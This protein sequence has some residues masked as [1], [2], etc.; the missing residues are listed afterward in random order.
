MRFLLALVM[1]FF[2]AFSIGQA[3][4]IQGKGSSF[5]L[6]L[7]QKWA[8]IYQKQT[9]VSI[10][11]IDSGS[12][13]GLN[14]IKKGLT[15]FTASNRPMNEEELDKFNLLQ[16]PVVMGGV[17]PVVNMANVGP[18][19]MRLS[20]SVLVDI[21]SGKINR[22]TDPAIR[23][24]NPDIFLPA[25]PIIVITRQDPS[26]TTYLLSHYLSRINPD[27]KSSPGVGTAI[28][29]PVGVSV[30][31]FEKLMTQFFR[32]PNSITYV[33]YAVARKNRL[34]HVQLQNQAGSF[35]SPDFLSIQAAARG[36]IWRSGM[37]NITTNSPNPLAWPIASPSYVILHR[38]PQNPDAAASAQQAL[39][40]FEWA[41]GYG[42]QIAD[43]MN[44]VPMPHDVKIAVVRGITERLS[45]D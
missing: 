29:F 23:R 32:S 40:F 27:W 18:G 3:Q 41:Y 31:G 37:A 35:V 7:Y 30:S 5:P 14:A 10:D 22:W 2:V 20:S 9:G 26:G 8:S 45:A 11:Y 33:D 16:F 24:L 36:T 13:E 17:V 15:T 6:I 25:A 34:A 21:Y 1:N 19:R 12:T 42:D 44:F 28:K 39:A 43:D 4:T 38:K